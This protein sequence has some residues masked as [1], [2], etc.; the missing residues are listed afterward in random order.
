LLKLYH[1]NLIGYQETGD[2]EFGLY[3]QDTKLAFEGNLKTQPQDWIYRD[4]RVI[5]SRN[6][7]GHRSKEISD[8]DKDFILFIG[9]SITV[10]SAVKLE[11]TFPY[12]VSQKLCIDYYNL[13]VEGAGWDLIAYNLGSWF[14]N[15]K[16]KPKAIVI[17]WPQ[18]SRTFRQKQENVIP[19]GPWS[20]KS[21]IGHGISELDWKNFES[22]IHTDYFD[23][24]GNVIKNSIVPLIESQSIKVIEVDQINSIDFGRDL[25]HPGTKTHELF[26]FN[27][28]KSFGQ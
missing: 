12:L 21:N 2:S 8:L 5:Y 14:K 28:L 7:H 26:S 19:I 25:K 4:K 27:I 3:G 17:N 23:H 10:G 1:E 9:C 15:I 16:R 20:C 22:I 18:L 6:S 11:E 24:Y 13:A